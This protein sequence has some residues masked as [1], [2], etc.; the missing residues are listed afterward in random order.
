MHSTVRMDD[1]IRTQHVE[2]RFHGQALEAV[3]RG[4]IEDR[5]GGIEEVHACARYLHALIVSHVELAEILIIPH[6]LAL[7]DDDAR[8]A[9]LRTDWRQWVWLSQAIFSLLASPRGAVESAQH[10]VTIA[11]VVQ[12]G[13]RQEC[14]HMAT[15]GLLD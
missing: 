2:L 7:D 13:V 8:F 4:S 12:E 1:V 6:L 10:L 3:A 11:R 15:L 14:R 9:Q 5:G